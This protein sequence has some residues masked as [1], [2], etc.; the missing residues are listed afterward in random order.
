MG[1]VTDAVT[2]ASATVVVAVTVTMPCCGNGDAPAKRMK[3]KRTIE[4]FINERVRSI[5]DKLS[6]FRSDAWK[7]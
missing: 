4:T 3:D 6:L 1:F 7:W 5:L 2:V